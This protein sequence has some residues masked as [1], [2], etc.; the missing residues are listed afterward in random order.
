MWNKYQMASKRKH[1]AS[2]IKGILKNPPIAGPTRINADGDD[3]F[4]P[5]PTAQIK[6]IVPFFVDS[7]CIK[8]WLKI[9]LHNLKMKF[10]S[11]YIRNVTSVLL[12]LTTAQ[13][14]GKK[15]GFEIDRHIL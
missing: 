5:P 6:G 7:V 10:S 11:F 2:H 12:R 1:D 4:K 8:K 13:S 15:V 9:F 3:I 14:T